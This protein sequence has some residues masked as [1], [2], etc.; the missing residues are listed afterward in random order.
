MNKFRN[1]VQCLILRTLES[2]SRE[3]KPTLECLSYQL[4]S[5]FEQMYI[6]DDLF[7]LFLSFR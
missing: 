2:E 5:L 3:I 6:L 4:H 1:R 7:Y